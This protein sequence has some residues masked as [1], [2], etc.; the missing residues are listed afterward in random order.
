MHKINLLI[1]VCQR[2]A[3]RD[4]RHGLPKLRNR[5]LSRQAVGPVN[6]VDLAARFAGR[7]V[8]LRNGPTLEDQPAA[9]TVN[10]DVLRKPASTHHV[11]L[12]FHAHRVEIGVVDLLVQGLG[13]LVEPLHG[14]VADACNLKPEPSCIGWR[15]AGL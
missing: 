10:V 6:R 11:E 1:G 15:H 5:L 13:R 9:L 8:A 2:P 7:D 3:S 14:L 4:G 12:A